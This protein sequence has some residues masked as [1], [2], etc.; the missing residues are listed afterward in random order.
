M[1]AKNS[2][3]IFQHQGDVQEYCA[4]FLSIYFSLIF[5]G[6]QNFDDFSPTSLFNEDDIGSFSHFMN[7]TVQ[8]YLRDQQMRAKHQE[9]LLKLKGKAVKVCS[10]I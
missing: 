7:I 3:I 4:F 8:Q 10:A 2:E 9:M 1:A 5:L 6:R